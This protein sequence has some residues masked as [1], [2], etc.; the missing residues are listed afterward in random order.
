MFLETNA[1]VFWVESK[2]GVAPSHS[3]NNPTQLEYE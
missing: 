1:I 2:F 3:W